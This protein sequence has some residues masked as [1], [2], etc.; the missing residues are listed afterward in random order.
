M[1]Q[2]TEKDLK[3]EVNDMRERYP[4]LKDDELFVA[5]FMKCFVTDTEVEGVASLVGGAKDKGLDAVHIDDASC[6][7]F[8]IQGKYHQKAS[9]TTEKRSDILAFADLARS[10]T[11]D[12]AYRTYR[13]GLATDAVGKADEA[14]KRIKSRDYRLQLYFVTTGKCSAPLIK[15]S[16][17][18]VRRVSAKAD[19]NI[20]DG[21]RILR[22]LSDYLDGVAP[23]VPLLEI[24]LE[25][26][27]GVTLSGVLQRFDRHTVI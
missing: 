8:I 4:K 20:I 1:A 5:W 27:Q 26:G 17:S 9:S 21:K 12:E 7:V 24:E 15:E 25:S 13:S 23:P 18:I 22:L 16:E 2:V 11:E 19:I 10:F 6:K 14:R 3:I